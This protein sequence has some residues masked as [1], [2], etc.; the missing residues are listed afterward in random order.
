MLLITAKPVMAENWKEFYFDEISFE[1]NKDSIKTGSD[2]Y[3]H[4]TIRTEDYFD[5][6]EEFDEYFVLEDVLDFLNIA[7]EFLYSNSTDGYLYLYSA[8]S[9]NKRRLYYKSAT[10]SSYKENNTPNDYLDGIVRTV[11]PK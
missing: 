10:T 8:I 2:G 1:I 3:T 11:C 6:E 4:F 7:D 9:C 5:L